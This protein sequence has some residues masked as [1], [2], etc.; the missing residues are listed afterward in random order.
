MTTY[1]EIFALREFRTLFLGNAFTVAGRTIQMLALSS[2]VYAATDAPLLAA[3]ALL[4]GLL[5]QA[6]GALTLLSFADRVR[7]RIFL[8]LWSAAGVLEALLLASGALPIA[9]MLALIMVFGVVDSLTSAVRGALLAEVLPGGYVLGR[10]I[11]N[12]SVGGM[13]ILGFAV[14][15]G[16][17]AA[18]GPRGALLVSAVLACWATLVTALGLRDRPPR[19]T[20]RAGVATTFRLNRSLWAMTSIRPLLVA[21]WLPN[22]LIVGAEAMYVPYAEGAAGVLF[23]AGAAGMLTGDV[24]IGRWMPAPARER[25]ISPLQALLAL[26]YLLFVFPPPMPVAAAAVFIASIGYAGTLGLQQ[27]L[28]DRVPTSLTGQAIGLEGSGRMTFQAVGAAVIGT[29]AEQT[30]PAAAMTVAGAASLL[31]TVTL[32]SRLRRFEAASEVEQDSGGPAPALSGSRG[33]PASPA[34]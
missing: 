28:V 24:V 16:L 6:I 29:V 17:I 9:G 5:P 1:R 31:V 33:K 12:V 20:G 7:P 3:L 8:T 32:W 25:W 15:G 19:A 4:G 14:G 30:G 18:L 27:R 34:G 21:A 13:Q 26:P 2:L 22:G 23:V 10:S 11:L